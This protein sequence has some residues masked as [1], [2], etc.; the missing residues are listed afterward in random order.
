MGNVIRVLCYIIALFEGFVNISFAQFI[1]MGDI[2]MGF[3][4][5]NRCDFVGM[6]VGMDQGRIRLHAVYGVGNRRQLLIDHLDQIAGFLGDFG[7]FCGNCGH[8]FAL[9]LHRFVGQEVFILQVQ[10]ATLG[11]PFAGDHGPHAGKLLGFGYVDADDLRMGVRAPLHL[12][13]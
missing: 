2:C 7:G 8:G 1:V 13:V 3:G 11:I 5:E 4:E 12:G 9:I 10:A 6:Q